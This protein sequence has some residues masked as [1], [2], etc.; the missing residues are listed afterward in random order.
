M[1]PAAFLPNDTDPVPATGLT[2]AQNET[3]VVHYQSVHA[4][5][6]AIDS[7]KDPIHFWRFSSSYRGRVPLQQS[8]PVRSAFFSCRRLCTIIATVSSV[9]PEE[10]ARPIDASLDPAIQ[11][12]VASALLRKAPGQR[13][14]LLYLWKHRSNSVSEYSIGRDVF[15]RRPDFDPKTDATVRVQI[16][17]LRQRL[18]DYYE[19]DGKEAT[20]RV[21]I[22]MGEYRIEILDSPPPAPGPKPSAPLRRDGHGV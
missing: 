5:L 13:E 6:S 3:R 20:R 8:S 21:H 19:Q 1:T 16:S 15:G 10:S 4:R 14:L 9:K 17:R 22:P 18:K 12:V 11:A 2:A 7:E